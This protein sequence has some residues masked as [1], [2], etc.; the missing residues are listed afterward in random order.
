MNGNSACGL[1]LNRTLTKTKYNQTYTKTAEDSEIIWFPAAQG[2]FYC[3]L[4]KLLLHIPI[5]LVS[6]IVDR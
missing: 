2:N 6:Y 5:S 3:N 1:L 4:Y